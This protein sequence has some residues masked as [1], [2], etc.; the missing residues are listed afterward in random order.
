MFQTEG[1]GSER[2]VQNRTEMRTVNPEF[3]PK[4]VEYEIKAT[5]V[6]SEERMGIID[7]AESALMSA[8]DRYFDEAKGGQPKATQD[9]LDR[10][11]ANFKAAVMAEFGQAIMN[12]FFAGKTFSEPVD[13]MYSLKFEG[14]REGG[15]SL[16]GILRSFPS[17]VDLDNA[18]R[19]FKD[20]YFENVLPYVANTDQHMAQ[21]SSE[22][23]KEDSCI[24][25]IYERVAKPVPAAPSDLG[26]KV[27][28]Q[29]L[30]A[31][32]WKLKQQPSEQKQ[33]AGSMP[34][35]H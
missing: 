11:S 9:K 8:V 19:A 15:E 28:E 14:L 26:A 31:K 6:G 35:A 10:L 2:V 33:K 5:L 13:V 21:S 7:R 24:I 30:S 17:T 1:N 3:A 34:G 16:K 18:Y 27:S 25:K 12:V 4:K 32:E 20:T 29:G 22:K 23:R